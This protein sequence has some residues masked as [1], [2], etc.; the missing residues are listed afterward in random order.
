[1]ERALLIKESSESNYITPRN[2]NDFEL[3]ELQTAVGGLI[4]IIRITDGLI[5]VINDEGKFTCKENR[6]ATTI[7]RKCRAIFSDDFIAGDVII[8]KSEMVK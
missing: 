2:G 4:D 1:M 3:D 5:M 8:C 7:A 6:A